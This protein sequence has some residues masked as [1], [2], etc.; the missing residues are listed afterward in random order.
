[1]LEGYDYPSVLVSADYQILAINERYKETFGELTPHEIHHC[2]QVSHGYSLPCDQSGESCPLAN[3]KESGTRER[4]L[5]IH[6]TPRGKEY[7]DVDM[8]PIYDES[9]ELQFFVE[10]LKPLEIASAETS[11]EQMVGRSTAFNDMVNKINLVA[12][13]KTSVLLLGES[14]TGKELA[15]RAIHQ[16]S[17]LKD[18][19]LVIVE[20][21]GLPET[22]FESELFGH[23][24]GAFTGATQNK[25][26]LMDS[27]EGGTLFLDEIGD[28]PL[29]MQVKLL[30]LLETNT[31]R[32][33]G[34]TLAKHANF[35]LICATHK[36]IPTLIENGEFR[37]DLY[38]R[39][40]AFPINLP[41]LSERREDIPL[42]ANSL[43][44]KLSPGANYHLTESAMQLLK[45][46][47]YPGN[48]RELRNILERVIIYAKSNVVD[49]STLELCLESE[50]STTR[51][52]TQAQESLADNEKRYL[53]E[54]LEKCSGNKQKAAKIAGISLRSLYRK[55]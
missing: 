45:A 55:L 11:T 21:A 51:K 32:P 4:V 48:I 7:V 9:G 13:H 19:P 37:Q 3:C 27:V 12:E 46:Q 30:R 5:H 52:N 18:K 10:M 33:V 47:S 20:C 29:G 1:M 16:A 2:Y 31:Y 8:L 54:L 50:Q 6:N 40:N 43:L 28:V 14:G 49:I 25:P 34:S 26:G 17:N 22:L 44:K 24:K 23:V 41:S 35:R 38:Y 42:I 15:A 39:I 53:K 36:N